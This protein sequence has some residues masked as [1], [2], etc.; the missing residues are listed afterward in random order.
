M[1]HDLTARTTLSKG[2]T[3]AAH[4]MLPFYPE[5][6]MDPIIT[7]SLD[8]IDAKTLPRD[9]ATLDQAAMD[10]LVAS[11]AANGLRQPIEVWQLSTP[12]PPLTH[13]LIAGFRRLEAHRRLHTLRRDGSF[14]TIP[15]FL[16]SPASL[17]QALAAMVDEN[18]C[19]AQVSPWDKARLLVEVVTQG[20]FPTIDAALA[21]LHATTS[22]QKRARLRATA[23][24]VEELEGLLTTPEVMVERHMLRLSAALR[25]GFTELFHQILSEARGQSFQTQWAALLPT[26][27]EAEKGEEDTPA[28]AKSPRRPRRMLRLKQGLIIRREVTPTGYALCFTGPEARKKGLMDD[29]M[30]A[31]ERWFQPQ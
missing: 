10:D 20:L 2:N 24:V 18:E 1:R 17:P 9:R 7:L 3:P 23:T 16:R 8:A 13:G 12:A 11:I 22:R 30:D 21:E 6:P 25:G 31:V 5:H 19:R 28:T 14:A 15:A 27:L 26:L 29:V 4:S